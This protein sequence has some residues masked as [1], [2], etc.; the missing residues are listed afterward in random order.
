MNDDMCNFFLMEIGCVRYIVR[1][2]YYS[3]GSL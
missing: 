3:G 1:C 2:L